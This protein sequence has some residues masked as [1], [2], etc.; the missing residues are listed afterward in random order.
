MAAPTSTAA[1]TS[2]STSEVTI[3][4]LNP[5]VTIFSRPFVRTGCEVGVRMSAIRLSSGDL[6]IYN[7]TELDEPTRS[8]LSSLG[9]VKY[10]VTPNLVHHMFAGPFAA[11][12]PEARFIGPEG[13]QAKK[14]DA[15]V[16]FAVEMKDAHHDHSAD[17]GWG[18]DVEYQYVNNPTPRLL[19]SI[20]SAP[21]TRLCPLFVPR[22]YFP[23][24]AQ[25]EIA[26]FHKPTKTLVR[27][28]QT[29]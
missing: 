2:A 9:T 4:E 25:K 27:P 7:P 15:G 16:T 1:S 19:V 3:R 21:L 12:F 10:V 26:L 18:T 13:I 5:S 6:V 14:K 8:K 29:A 11:A 22:R 20:A 24:F 17:I 28:T 23:D